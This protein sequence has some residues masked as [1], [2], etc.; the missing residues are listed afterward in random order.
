MTG[1]QTD[2]RIGSLHRRVF[3]ENNHVHLGAPT[4]VDGIFGM[5]RNFN[6][7]DQSTLQAVISVLVLY[8]KTQP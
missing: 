2:K 8:K 4:M 3:S 6:K 5:A 1:L 7:F